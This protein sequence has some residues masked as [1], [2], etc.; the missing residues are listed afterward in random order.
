MAWWTPAR[1]APGTGSPR[2]TVAPTASTI[3]SKSARSCAAVTSRPAST[4][5]R[6]LSALGLHLPDPAIQVTLFHLELGDPVAQ[7]P[8]E[9]VGPLEHGDRV[10]GAGQLLG[11]GQ[12]GRAGA[13]D[14]DLAARRPP[15]RWWQWPDP[16]LGPGPVD[17]RH[18]DVLDRHRVGVDASTQALSH[19]AGQSRPVNSGKLL[20][21]CSRSRRLTPAPITVR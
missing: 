21:A 11:R 3:A 2:A 5:E 6:N 1:S 19:G 16:A 15:R 12:P 10:P 13:D 17:D 4:P 9:R 20:V 14:R 7:Q 8:A 18:L